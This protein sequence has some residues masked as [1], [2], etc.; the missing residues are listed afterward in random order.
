[1][2]ERN[3]VVLKP[4]KDFNFLKDNS[5]QLTMNNYEFKISFI[6]NYKFL[7]VN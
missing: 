7:I 2:K 5:F 6:I 1:L 3:T 4:E